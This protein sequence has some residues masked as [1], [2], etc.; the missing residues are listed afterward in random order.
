MGRYSLDKDKIKV[1]LLEGVNP[2]AVDSFH[3]AG[4]NQVEYLKGALDHDELIEKIKDVH[5]IGIRSRTHLTDD[6]FDAA[7][8][9]CAVGCFCIGTNQVDLESASRHGI[10]VFNAPFSNTRSVTELVTGEYLML[11]RRIPEKNANC[12]RGVWQ[13]NAAGCFEARGKTLGIVGYGHIGTQVGIVAE[14]LGLKVIFF[15]TE[16]KLC[17]GNAKQVDTLDELL[18]Y[19]DIVTMHVPETPETKLMIGAAQF[20]EMKQGVIFVN[21]SRGSVVDIDALADALDSKHVSGAALDVHPVEP[22]TGNDPFVSRLQKYDNVILTPHIGASTQEAQKNIGIEVADKLVKYSDNG[23]TLTAVNFPEV[24]LPMQGHVNR[25]LHVHKS[26]PGI[27]NSI[28]SVFHSRNVNVVSQYLQT[29]GTMGYV[30]IDCEK[31]D[32]ALEIERELKALD[33]TIKCR[34]LL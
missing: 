4:Y 24:S 23:S 11:L 3:R 22:A 13:K 18:K 9:L 30:V 1:L 20:A 26:V 27:L 32:A 19:S 17:F 5:F 2:S 15:D 8:K 25:Y 28:N 29:S 12:H 16:K 6:V 10:P 31:T 34:I 21:A 7:K 33:G 14:A